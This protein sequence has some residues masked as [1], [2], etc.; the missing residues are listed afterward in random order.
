[1]GKNGISFKDI[2]MNN[3]SGNLEGYGLVVTLKDAL[4]LFGDS[5]KVISY[6]KAWKMFL[7]KMIIDFPQ[8]NFFDNVL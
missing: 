3:F 8:S 4:R 2:G 1:M 7:F 5:D 6:L